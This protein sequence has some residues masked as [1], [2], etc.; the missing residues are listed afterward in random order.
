MFP[1]AALANANVFRGK[2]GA[3]LTPAQLYVKLTGVDVAHGRRRQG[4][5]PALSPR[6]SHPPPRPILCACRR[7]LA[8][9]S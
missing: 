3:D 2:D 5:P 7:S 6:P 9:R 1:R 8:Q 4:R